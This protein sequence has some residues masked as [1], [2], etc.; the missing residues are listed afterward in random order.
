M[1]TFRGLSVFALV[2]LL[3]VVLA[4]TGCQKSTG[5][6]DAQS[7]EQQA[8]KLEFTIA[9]GGAGGPY[10]TIATGLAEIWN[11]NIPEVNVTVASTGASVI[12]NRMVDEGTAELAFAMSDVCFYGNRGIEMFE[13]PLANVMGFAS[14]HTNFVQLIATKDSGIET[15]WDLKGKRVGVGAPGSGTELNARAIL[16]AHDIT[17]E[18]LAKA[19][20]LS[21]AETCEQLANKNI[22][23]G[24]LTG[25]LPIAAITE[26]ATT[27]DIKIIPIDPAIVDKLREEFPIYLSKEIPGGTYKG[28][29]RPVKTVAMKNYIL[30]N[31]DVDEDLAYK[32]V[33][34]M[35][36]NLDKL[37][38]YHAAAKEIKIETATEAMVLPLHPGVERFYK[39]KGI[40]E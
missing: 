23:A 20:Y 31:K 3:A 15:V 1:K 34:V 35:Y 2:I 36:E 40:V 29:D 21:Y 10:H 27:Q 19:D 7:G 6:Q 9:T 4:F 24:F 37:S 13:A 22:D 32:L 38:E 8:Q 5:S 26:L 28:V 11:S 39:E 33:S 12:N 18:D 17:Y 14:A 25:G 30:I 16:A